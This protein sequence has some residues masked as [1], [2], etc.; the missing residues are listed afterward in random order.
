M[1]AQRGQSR[2]CSDQGDAA[3]LAHILRTDREQ[4]QPWEA[5]TP[6][7]RHIRSQVTLLLNLTKSITR[8]SNQLRALL[9]RYYPVAADLFSC[10]DTQIALA[11]I[12]TYPTPQAAKPIF[13]TFPI[14]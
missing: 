6:S 4:H 13:R 14:E 11:F 10:L 12:E 7:T 9:W 8:Y 2:S 5:D 1:L 3:V